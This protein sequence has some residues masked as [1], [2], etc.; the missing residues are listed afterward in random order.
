MV[1]MTLGSGFCWGGLSLSAH[2]MKAVGQWLFLKHIHISDAESHSSA[3][4]S[5]AAN[6]CGAVFMQV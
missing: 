6:V 5:T 3:G 4:V 1:V 2:T